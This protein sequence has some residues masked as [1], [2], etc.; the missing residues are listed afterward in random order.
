MKVQKQIKNPDPIKQ[1][2]KK[3]ITGF[4]RLEGQITLENAKTYGLLYTQIK[5]LED[6]M[7]K[8]PTKDEFYRKMDEAMTE[9]QIH[10]D[11]Q[12]VMRGQIEE[13]EEEIGS[14]KSHLKIT[15]KN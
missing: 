12:V 13:H 3:I 15:S 1:L 11:E 4:R 5:S 10:R 6:K 2:E 14:I 8:L 7:S 9:L